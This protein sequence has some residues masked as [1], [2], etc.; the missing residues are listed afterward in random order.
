MSPEG[1]SKPSYPVFMAGVQTGQEKHLIE[2]RNQG[3]K[4]AV[5]DLRA[6]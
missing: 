4:G 1:P 2:V 5:G 6:L 3:K